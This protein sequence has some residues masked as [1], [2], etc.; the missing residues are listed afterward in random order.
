MDKLKVFS[1]K[2]GKALEV[3]FGDD[4]MVTTPDGIIVDSDVVLAWNNSFESWVD[5]GWNNSYGS[6]Q[7]KGWNNSYGSWID[8]GWS[9]SSGSWMDKGWSNSS[10]SWGDA[11]GSGGGC[12]I[13]SACVES[14]GL[15]DTCKELQILRQ[16][17]DELVQKDE[18]FRGKV[19]EYY[20]KAPLIVQAIEKTKESSAIYDKLFHEMILPCV[21]YL[22]EG[23]T[24]EAKELYLKCYGQMAEKYLAR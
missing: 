15:S 6:W 16:Y 14:Q 11:G 21:A 18:D 12:F 23:K 22:E 13:T 17:R 24:S 19:L 1:K 3:S 20:R 5:Q 8:Q 9:N 2:M 10:G 4:G 7:D